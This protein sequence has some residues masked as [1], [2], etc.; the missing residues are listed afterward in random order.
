MT[1]HEYE[2]LAPEEKE[3]FAMRV[4]CGETFDRRSLDEVL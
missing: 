1:A 3:H 4:K 2:D